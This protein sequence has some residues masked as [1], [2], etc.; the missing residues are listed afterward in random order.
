MNLICSKCS[1]Q[2]NNLAIMCPA[3]GPPVGYAG[4]TPL[5]FEVVTRESRA[6]PGNPALRS[7]EREP[8]DDLFQRA[9]TAAFETLPSSL[10]D[11]VRTAAAGVLILVGLFYVGMALGF[12]GFLIGQVDIPLT[13]ADREEMLLGPRGSAAVGIAGC[14]GLAALCA[15]GARALLLGR[16]RPNRRISRQASRIRDL[17]AHVD[18][19]ANELR[20]RPYAGLRRLRSTT[21]EIQIDG[22][23][24][25]IA[26]TIQPVDGERVQVV[27]EGALDRSWLLSAKFRTQKGF[28]K[29]DAG[30]ISDMT[31]FELWEFMGWD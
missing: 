4:G 3:C 31:D 17:Q 15:R 29:T 25:L 11:P 8:A 1:G 16:N 26:V 28:Y 27:V 2:V 10:R 30:A 19:I 22:R 13:E 21:D 7:E 9:T 20:E 14:I 18:R 12:A 23:K 6:W 5:P 24:G